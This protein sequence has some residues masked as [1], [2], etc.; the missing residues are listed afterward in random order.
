M[1][2]LPVMTLSQEHYALVVE[3]FPG[4]TEQAKADAYR[5]WLGNRLIERV[6]SRL[7]NQAAAR[8]DA[9]M[10]AIRASMPPRSPEPILPA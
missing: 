3:A 7:L 4:T 8:R 2:D 9:E 5:A 1:P 6:E 10:A